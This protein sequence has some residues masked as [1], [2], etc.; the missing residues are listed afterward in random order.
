L[1]VAAVQLAS[2]LGQIDENLTE[3]TA[4]AEQAA[5]RG[6]ELILFHELMP[7]GYAWDETAW[8]SAE[9]ADGPTARWLRSTAARLH[10]WI[11]TTFLEAAGEDFWNTFVLVAPDGNEGGRVRKEFPSMYE[12]RV[13]RGEPGP[14][15]I[16]T[17]LGRVGVAICFDAHTVAVARK[18]VAADV[19]LL[20]APHCYCVPTHPSRGVSEGDI[21]RLTRNVAAIAP[22][23]ARTLGV[24]TIVTNRVGAWDT[25]KGSGYVFAGQATIADG[26]G[27]VVAHLDQEVGVAVGEVHLDPRLK[28]HVAPRAY[29]RWIYPGPPGREVLRLIEWWEARR[30]RGAVQRR[31]DAVRTATSQA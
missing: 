5:A 21:T 6:A 17:P 3:A 11:G 27:S 20:L 14:H 28:T 2:R 18:L 24:P 12:A 30:Y 22:L 31:R 23:Y 29:S 16:A 10:A 19:D 1:R 15:V 8:S 9:P 4:L 25:S 13:F 7:G 26:D